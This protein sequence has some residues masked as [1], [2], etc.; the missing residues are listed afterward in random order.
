MH[1]ARDDEGRVVEAGRERFARHLGRVA[2]TPA[3]RLACDQRA[4]QQAL[5]CRALRR[6][7]WRRCGAGSRRFRARW[8]AAEVPAPTPDGHR[9]HLTDRGMQAW[10]VGKAFLDTPVDLRF[11]KDQP[12]ITDHRQVVNYITE[13]RC[14]YQ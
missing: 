7:A 2:E 5:A 12:E 6:S 3:L 8:R 10:Q 14:F 4:L 13:R 1:I 9:N 11:G